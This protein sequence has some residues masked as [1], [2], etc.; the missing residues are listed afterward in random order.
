MAKKRYIFDEEKGEFVPVKRGGRR[1][2]RLIASVVFL[3]L[4]FSA[5]GLFLG[6]HYVLKPRS[7][8]QAKLS[9]ELEMM[10]L[11]YKLLGK[12]LEQTEGVL[13]DLEQRDENIY[14]SF[15]ELAPL[16]KGVR[17]GGYGGV[18]RYEDFAHL[19]FG[20]LVTKTSQQLDVLSKK[21]V[22]QSRSLDEVLRAA[23]QKEAMFRHIPAMQPIANKDLKRLASGYGMRLHP[24][25]KVG[26]MHW[27]IDFS[28]SSGTPIYA[29]GDAV[30]SQA[31]KMG[32]YGNVV[33][34]NHGY[35]YESLYAHQSR[36]KVKKGQ[37]VKR[38]D[39]IG[40]VGSTG[41]S[42]GAHLHYEIHKNGEKLDPVNFFNLDVSPDEFK[43]L[44]E[45][46]QM[47]NVSLD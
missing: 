15:F 8:D 45:Q 6:Y 4:F 26:R 25:L 39:V 27:G 34:L 42:S 1:V 37:K 10:E 13:T 7:A 14:R 5:I 40:Y 17:S 33:V 29:T 41:L 36:I 23:E 44:H 21:L 11:Q 19:T 30:V 35:G 46:S 47:M 31:G 32:G 3:T 16:D 24:I 22:V 12:R 9:R 43:K 20:D 2:F 18:D 28:A 38:G